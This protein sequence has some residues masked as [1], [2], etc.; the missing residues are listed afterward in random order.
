MNPDNIVVIFDFDGVIIDSIESLYGVYLDFLKMFRIEGNKEEFKLLN[1]PKLP[2]IISILKKKY[3]LTPGR[4]TL[5]NI[6]DKKL[7]SAY[8]RIRP[9]AGVEEAL[10]LIKRK[11][12][13][14][15]L[16]SSSRKNEIKSVLRR[17]D[18]A[19][20]FDFVVTGDD[21]ERAKPSPDLYNVIRAKYP[22]HDYYVI[23]DSENG[24]LAATRAGMR[25]IFFNPDNICPDKICIDK[26]VTYEINSLY[27]MEHIL[28]EIELNCFTIAS[29]KEIVL[30]AGPPPPDIPLSK[31]T[32]I[33]ALWRAE[34]RKRT[35][36]NGE[37]VSYKSHKKAGETLNI[38]CF[39]TQY[40][41]FLAQ[42]R[43]PELD[44]S[45]NPIGVSGII[46]DS[47][48][49][50]VH[51]VRQ[52]VTEYEGYYEFIPAGSIDPSKREGDLILF[53]ETLMEEFAE[54]TGLLTKHIQKIEPFSFVF[55]KT[56]GVYDICSRIYTRG[57]VGDLLQARQNEEYRDIEAV[58]LD[59][60]HDRI[61]SAKYV[62][63]SKLMFN[64]LYGEGR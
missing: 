61:E 16:A 13:K 17:F 59:K 54:E 8:K 60:I 21:V 2:E 42:L 24:L 14:I 29:P 38:E 11:K 49:N 18:L 32:V 52:K 58:P 33:E 57:P 23:E 56:H 12:I 48:E 43:A 20:Y 4:E 10:K 35:V 3:R 19:P 41:F 26:A 62:P 28:M 44:L 47:E 15:A 53:Q 40:K 64:H 50:T 27:R 9:I 45:I 55:D 6:Y 63:T 34:S 7:S 31:K 46:I 37:I 1:G 25:T 51:A 5:L 39:I 30:K 36:F 22:G